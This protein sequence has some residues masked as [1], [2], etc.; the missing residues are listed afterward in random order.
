MA[1]TCLQEGCKEPRTTGKFCRLH[2]IAH[3]KERQKSKEKKLN[4]YIEAI[5]KKYPNQY[6]DVMKKDLSS[7]ENFKKAIDELEI[8]DME[9]DN[10]GDIEE[11]IK[12]AK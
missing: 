2:Y 3:W 10:S 6:L 1:K 11:F 7:P 8:E 4:Q 9:D 5:T 12:K